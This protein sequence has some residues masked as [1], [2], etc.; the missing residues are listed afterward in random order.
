MADRY[1]V[2][3]DR[4]IP[5]ALAALALF[6]AHNHQLPLVALAVT[7]LFTL[8]LTRFWSRHSTDA[9][10]YGRQTS[11]SRAFAGDTLSLEL[12]LSNDKLLPLPWV[13]IDDRIPDP[14]VLLPE[15]VDIPHQSG[16]LK[17]AGSVSWKENISWSYKMRCS[18][19][20]IYRIGP[21]TVTSGDPF[22]FFPR[23][24]KMDGTVKLVVYPRLI[25]LEKLALPPGF[26][27]GEAKPRRWI[28]EDPSRTVGV[29]DYRR[30]D[31]FRRI[32]WKATARRQQ[33]QVK[34]H[35]PT[36]TL[37]VALFLALD[38]FGRDVEMRVR[39]D[40]PHPRPLSLW[41][42][43]DARNP[44][45]RTQNPEP[46]SGLRTQDS[47]PRTQDS[48][49][50]IKHSALD[51]QNPELRTQNSARHSALGFEYAVSV[52]A[53]LAHLL[54]GQRYPVG[55]YLNGGATGS[56]GVVEL[57]PGGS[58]DQLITIL[59]LLAGVEPLPSLSIEKLL[60]KIATRLPWGSSV[61]VVAGDLTESLVATL[62]AVAREGQKPVVLSMGDTNGFQGGD[63]IILHPLSRQGCEQ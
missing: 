62:Q 36:T 3:F 44:E 42:R 16:C 48:A 38:T 1:H 59:E 4:W 26:P 24:R 25:P 39:G 10:L 7:I 55:L 23:S 41:G 31:S 43:G 56:E 47:A 11:D 19:R 32:H 21:A 6:G 13:E 35:E 45:P 12:R 52:V 15:G 49:L 58:Q 60:S 27:L 53:S 29:R 14:L 5:A 20:G 2:W 22:G 50:N 51:S 40:G 61:V 9:L 34:L 57:P 54:I 46:P 63:G 8:L 28:F 17:L 37:E 18:R 30:E 33:L